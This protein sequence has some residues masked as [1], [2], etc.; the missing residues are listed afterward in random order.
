MAV[1]TVA[2]VEMGGCRRRRLN[3]NFL[4]EFYCF[5][6]SRSPPHDLEK[7]KPADGRMEAPD[8]PQWLEVIECSLAEDDSAICWDDPERHD[9]EPLDLPPSIPSLP[10][11]QAEAHDSTSPPGRTRRSAAVRKA[12]SDL[13]GWSASDIGD[14][15]AARLAPKKFGRKPSAA[16]NKPPILHK[17]PKKSAKRKPPIKPKPTA[18]GKAEPPAEEEVDVLGDGDTLRAPTIAKLVATMPDEE[19]DEVLVRNPADECVADIRKLLPL[20]EQ[21]AASEEEDGEPAAASPMDRLQQAVEQ[22]ECPLLKEHLRVLLPAVVGQRGA[23]LTT[24]G[25][26]GGCSVFYARSL[27]NATRLR[28]RLMLFSHKRLQA[29][30]EAHSFLL[31]RL[32]NEFLASYLNLLRFLKISGSNLAV[33]LVENAKEPAVRKANDCVRDFISTKVT[34]PNLRFG[35]ATSDITPLPNVSLVLVYPQ[36]A[37]EGQTVN[38]HAHENMFRNLLPAAVKCVE[39]VELQFDL[40]TDIRTLV[41]LCLDLVRRRVKELVKRR[42]DDHVF[43][44][45]WGISTL[46]NMQALQKVAGVAGV[47]NFAYPMR[48]PLGFRGTVDDSTCITY[49]ASLFVVGNAGMNVNLQE[50]QTMRK[51][52]ICDSG[53]IVV[54]GAD[55]HLYVS[56]LFLSVERVSQHCVDR[57]ILDHVVDFMKLVISEGGMTA[58]K[59]RGHLTPVQKPS[60]FDAP[61]EV[62]RGRWNLDGGSALVAPRPRRVEMRAYRRD[63]KGF[64]KPVVRLLREPYELP[65]WTRS[66]SPPP[67]EIPLPT[68]LRQPSRGQ[69]INSEDARQFFESLVQRNR[70]H[71]RDPRFNAVH[72]ER[73]P[74]K[75]LVYAVHS[76][77]PRKSPQLLKREAEEEDMKPKAEAA[78]ASLIVNSPFEPLVAVD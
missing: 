60:A 70:K 6:A 61:L 68:A 41:H 40:V 38:K 49:C 22:F 10:P 63:Q 66:P 43:L 34:D 2:G 1:R 15:P 55:D 58:G 30:E 14:Q 53:V 71:A 33:H 67:P 26:V 48:S 19:A 74:H 59:K 18:D 5:L 65:D 57:M 24:L 54:G 46:I 69:P 64:V 35:R 7:H 20:R 28:Q 25:V 56:P 44:A 72:P 8:S 4:L 51:N 75:P 52:M 45:G 17:T 62:L 16:K 42:P 23:D 27:A 31:H 11:I 37:M 76:S 32:S 13:K 47:L 29:I 9:V 39:K 78:V 21:S 50:L 77:D 36:V 3:G 73:P 12:A